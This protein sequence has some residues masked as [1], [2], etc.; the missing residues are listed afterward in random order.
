MVALAVD[1][2]GAQGHRWQAMVSVVAPQGLLGGPLALTIRA[3]RPLGSILSDRRRY[4][5]VHSNG[6]QVD[7]TGEAD[8][9]ARSQQALSPTQIHLP[10]VAGQGGCVHN[11]RTMDDHVHAVNRG[12]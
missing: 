12:P 2:A 5:P 9:G 11:T 1:D 7:E 6:A 3:D 10:H 4:I 8:L